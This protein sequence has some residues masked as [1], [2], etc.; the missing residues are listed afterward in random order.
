MMNQMVME[1]LMMKQ[2]EKWYD[3]DH[4]NPILYMGEEEVKYVIS[5]P[6]PATD[7]KFC[8]FYFY[9]LRHIPVK[10]NLTLD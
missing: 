4:L 7:L 2:R 6:I 3:K 8:G 5:P 1:L 9:S 10:K